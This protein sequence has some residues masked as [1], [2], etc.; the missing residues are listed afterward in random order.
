AGELGSAEPLISGKRVRVFPRRAG[1]L[2]PRAGQ[3][4]VEAG[5][6]VT[7]LLNAVKG[8]IRRSSNV[9][10]L[11][12]ARTFYKQACA[13][14]RSGC[15]GRSSPRRQ[16]NPSTAERQ[17]GASGELDHCQRARKGAS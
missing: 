1:T 5:S 7:E 16:R 14:S 6:S 2:P 10:N 15:G 13:P 12:N 17:S 11:R 8:K 9:H 4:S 3:S